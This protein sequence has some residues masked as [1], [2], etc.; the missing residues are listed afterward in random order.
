M[1]VSVTE[2][3]VAQEEGVQ[4]WH[5]SHTEKPYFIRSLRI[6]ETWQVPTYMEAIKIYEIEVAQSRGCAIVQKKLGSF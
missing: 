6:R 2:R 1:V 3:L 5:R 4:L